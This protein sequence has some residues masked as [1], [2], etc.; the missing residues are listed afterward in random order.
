[1][2]E[3]PDGT[4]EMIGTRGQVEYE[5]P[6]SGGNVRRFDPDPATFYVPPHP[7]LVNLFSALSW[8]VGCIE[9]LGQDAGHARKVLDYYRKQLGPRVES[10]DG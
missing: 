6:R 9:G 1:M 3:N 4:I 10:D 5:W 7:D 2:I 8:A